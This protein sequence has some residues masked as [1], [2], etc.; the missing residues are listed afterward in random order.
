VWLVFGGRSDVQGCC[1]L[2][3]AGV[4]QD[5]EFGGADGF[6]SLEGDPAAV[7]DLFDADEIAVRQDLP[8]IARYLARAPAGLRSVRIGP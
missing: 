8:D 5:R 2:G 3:C 1:W 4:A 7:C 6:D